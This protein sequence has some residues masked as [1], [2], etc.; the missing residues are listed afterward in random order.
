MV[1]FILLYVENLDKIKCCV[2]QADIEKLWM[3]ERK[4]RKEG[5]KKREWSRFRL[6]EREDRLKESKERQKR[7]DEEK[8]IGK[9]S[10]E[11]EFDNFTEKLN[12]NVLNFDLNL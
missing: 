12:R 9:I 3:K 4:R 5:S 6:Q 11:V 7:E 1:N 8:D 10:F 2:K